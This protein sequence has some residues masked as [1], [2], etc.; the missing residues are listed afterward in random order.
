M[1]KRE[2][3]HPSTPRPPD[4]TV[5]PPP[6]NSA[7]L[8]NPPPPHTGTYLNTGSSTRV[9]SSG[10]LNSTPALSMVYVPTWPPL[11]GWRVLPRWRLRHHW[12][13]SY[14][15]FSDRF[16]R[17]D[18]ANRRYTLDNLGGLGNAQGVASGGVRV[19]FRPFSPASPDQNQGSAKP[20]VGDQNRPGCNELR[21]TARVSVLNTH[22]HSSQFCDS[23][24]SR[25][26]WDFASFRRYGQRVI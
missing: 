16:C 14:L 4:K 15:G 26:S 13:H 7:P 3:F 10:K 21:K 22:I 23:G 1:R 17:R 24:N 19:V 2:V 11:K 6:R 20:K 5:H 18:L 9:A 8:H 12:A 25:S